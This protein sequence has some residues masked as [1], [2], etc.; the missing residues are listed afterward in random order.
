M[1][2]SGVYDLSLTLTDVSDR[3]YEALQIGMDGETMTGGFY[4]KARD[5]LNMMIKEWENQGIHLWTMKEGTLFLRVGQSIYPFGDSTTKL[6]NEYYTTYVTTAATTGATVLLVEDTAG[7]V[8][9]NPIGVIG[10][11][12]DLQWFTIAS[13][14]ADTSVTLSGGVLTD[15]VE[16]AVIYTYTL[17]SF[18]PVVRILDVRRKQLTDY[19]IP[20]LFISRE[21][22]MSLPNKNQPGNAI[23][24]Y[25]SRQLPYGT[26]YVWN[27]PS[28]SVPV[29]R[30][31]YERKLQ[32]M[33]NQSDTFDLPESWYGALI[34]N[35]AVRLIPVYGCS[36][37]RAMEIKELAMSTL[38]NA[39]GFDTDVYPITIN[40]Q[41]Y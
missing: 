9:G 34:Y 19:E 11:D 40:M 15:I 39:L 14:V 6:A 2:L 3:A 17:N 31:T 26:M 29:L 22:Y 28:T 13:F 20:I 12:N 38:N 25:Y 23:Q 37:K 7:F 35:L 8:N 24:A 41:R 36:S 1:S 18:V 5:F 27:A 33:V 21:K 30:F 16:N 32:I 10:E 4:N